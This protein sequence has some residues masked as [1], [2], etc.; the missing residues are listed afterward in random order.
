MKISAS[1]L[2]MED[3]RIKEL[4][5]SN[6]D[7]LHLDIMDGK[8]VSN[9]TREYDECRKLLKGTK[10]PKDIHL[11]VKDVK[12]YIDLYA[13]FK[14]EYITFHLEAVSN[15]MRIIRYLRNLDIKVGISIKPKTPL[16]ELMPYLEKVDLVLVMSVEPG[17]G[18][19]KFISSSSIKINKLKRLRE[20]NKYNYVIEVDGGINDTNVSKCHNADILVVGTYITNSKNFNSAIKKL[21]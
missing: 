21:L 11:M 2:S 1:Y 6:I 7:Y 16:E 14:P 4:D 19:Q 18:G 10:K 15:P 5:D 20:L 9:E 8:F 13:S 12:K 3:D 17:Y